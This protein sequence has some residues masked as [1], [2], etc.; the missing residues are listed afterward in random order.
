VRNISLHKGLPL[1]GRWEEYFRPDDIMQ[2]A[3]D[4]PDLNFII[5][6]SG[7]KHMMTM[8]PPGESGIDA[9]GYLPWTTDLCRMK[10]ENPEVTNVYPELGAVFGHSVV[11]HPDICGHL[12]GQIIAAFGADHVI[13]GTDCIWW[14]SPQWLIE[15]FRRFQIPAAQQEQFEYAAITDADRELIFGRNLAGLYGIDVEA[16]RTA[17]PGDSLARM[18]TA[19]LNNGPGRSNTQYGWVAV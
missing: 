10:L 2:A 14:G 17:L 6:H 12:L 1:P 16:Q 11:T 18:K 3:R 8:L 19:Y 7:M 9:D 5:Y 15:A 13:W 4:F